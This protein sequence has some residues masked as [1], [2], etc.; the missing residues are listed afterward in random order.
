MKQRP[1]E[2][3]LWADILNDVSTASLNKDRKS[4]IVFGDECVGKTSLINKLR[5]A[6]GF[7]LKQGLGLEYSFL[8]IRVRGVIR[9]TWFYWGY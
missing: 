2:E 3:D 6:E 7:T 1:E 4:L 8:D 5:R 9:S